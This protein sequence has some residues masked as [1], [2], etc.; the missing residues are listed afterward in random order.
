VPENDPKIAAAG[1]IEAADVSGIL[2]NNA[3][4]V[5]YITDDGNVYIQVVDAA[6]LAKISPL[7]PAN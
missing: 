2:A 7:Y 4:F 6:T 5:A 3:R 1:E